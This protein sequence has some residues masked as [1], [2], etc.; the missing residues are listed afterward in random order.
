[1]ASIFSKFRLLGLSWLIALGSLA[2]AVA[3]AT[4]DTAP[5]V[6][7]TTNMGSFVIQLN[8]KR[9]PLTV[10]NFLRYVKE[11]FYTNTL[12]HRV[13]SNFVI[14]GG[15]HSAVD[16]KLKPTHPDIVNE[17]GN[18]LTNKRG[19]VGMARA[20]A[21]HS[22]NS[23]FY[24]NLVDNPVLDPQASRWGYAVF[25]EVVEGMEVIERIGV[26]PTGKV[27]EF[28]QDAPLQPVIIEKIELIDKN[29]AVVPSGT[30]QPPSAPATENSPSASESTPESAQ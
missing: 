26:V 20:E 7:V 21:P 11:G 27:G 8:P 17:A 25:G 10:E 19:S 12:F 14:Q 30:P 5:R 6:R 4:D 1:M 28:E 9:A 16:G 22:G 24:I 18:G 23:Q 15:G 13:V 2:G 3:A 29:G